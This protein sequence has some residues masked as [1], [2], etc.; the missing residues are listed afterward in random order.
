MNSMKIEEYLKNREI[1]FEPTEKKEFSFLMEMEPDCRFRRCSAK[2]CVEEG[3]QQVRI[4]VE[5][6]LFVRRKEYSGVGRKL[7][8]INES[9]LPDCLFLDGKVKY[10]HGFSLDAIDGSIRYELVVRIPSDYPANFKL[11]SEAIESTASRTIKEHAEAIQRMVSVESLRVEEEELERICAAR[12]KTFSDYVKDFFNFILGLE[13]TAKPRT[14]SSGDEEYYEDYP[15]EEETVE[16]RPFRKFASPFTPVSYEEEF[17]E[18]DGEEPEE[19]SPVRPVPYHP[20]PYRPVARH[21][22][23]P[24]PPEF[25]EVDEEEDEA[26]EETSAD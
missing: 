14:A 13:D 6:P 15:A 23:A 16:D 17:E 5:M 1:A 26:E 12:P 4:S 25:D 19:E 2:L 21:A 24:V 11:I 3:G 22:A 18:E 10:R 9:L 7:A 8:I 20:I